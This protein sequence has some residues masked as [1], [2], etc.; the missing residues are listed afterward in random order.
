M[1]DRGTSDAIDGFGYNGIGV[2]RLVHNG[3]DIPN[4]QDIL[5]MRNSWLIG[6]ALMLAV[7][8]LTSCMQRPSSS[9]DEP[10]RKASEA[11]PNALSSSVSSATELSADDSVVESVV[12]ETASREGTELEAL[13]HE[14]DPTPLIEQSASLTHL[15]LAGDATAAHEKF[16]L[17]YRE[18]VTVESLAELSNKLRELFGKKVSK[19]DFLATQFGETDVESQTAVLRVRHLVAFASGKEAIS[20]VTFFL[21]TNEGNVED[22]ELASIDVRETWPSFSP[23]T[24]NTVTNSLEILCSGE[25][26]GVDR[27]DAQG[28]QQS[29]TVSDFKALLHPDLQPLIAEQKLVDFVEQISS[30]FGPIVQPTQ[31][32]HWSYQTE[33]QQLSATGTVTT[34]RDQVEIR[35]DFSNE[36][37]IGL[38]FI[39]LKGALSTL[40]LIEVKTQTAEMGK[41]FWEH[42]FRRELAQA[43]KLLAPKFQEELAMNEFESAILESGL[44]DTPEL[45][46]VE[47][48]VI[49]LS[50]RLERADAIGLVGIY[51]ITFMDGSQQ[52]VQCEFAANDSSQGLLYFANDFE[53][54]VPMAQAERVREIVSAFLST[55]PIRVKRLL[56]AAAQ[57]Y[58]DVGITRAFMQR[59][60]RLLGTG[61]VTVQ[62]IRV[63]YVYSRSNRLEQLRARLETPERSVAFVGT[64][65][66]GVLRSFSFVAPELK[67]FASAIIEI[68]DVEEFG[69]AFIAEW[70][71]ANETAQAVEK[72]VGDGEDRQTNL[73]KLNAHRDSLLK[74]HGHFLWSDLVSWKNTSRSSNEIQAIYELE[75]ADQTIDMQ[76]TFELSAIGA[77]VRAASILSEFK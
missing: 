10:A 69:S 35:A 49:R 2:A 23:K 22:V 33:G 38:S 29:K 40:D 3:D 9:K 28:E 72:M 16:A 11:S 68:G 54:I 74:K 48:D 58:F 75:F 51:L 64:T 66:A 70:M 37:L 71:K 42:I 41:R 19:I 31:W 56:D 65:Q 45:K 12:L 57:K 53:A 77:K 26:G 8:P 59:L 36:R 17:P 34:K 43:H 63:L 18:Q 1:C 27:V 13:A 15:L 52:T 76:L 6:W 50:N 44:A 25:F 4:D 24:W 60:Q 30:C 39:G 14:F 5:S 32:S 62:D 61:R 7:G 20:N 55:E 46:G 73:A 67:T 47:L 21:S